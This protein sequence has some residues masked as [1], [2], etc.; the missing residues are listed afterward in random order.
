MHLK[1]KVHRWGNLSKNRKT[2][3]YSESEATLIS[4]STFRLFI[5]RKLIFVGNV[6]L[7]RAVFLNYHLLQKIQRLK[8][9]ENFWTQRWS[10]VDKRPPAP[11]TWTSRKD[12]LRLACQHHLSL[13]KRWK[14]A[15]FNAFLLIR[16]SLI[17]LNNMNLGKLLLA[18]VWDL[19]TA[20]SNLGKSRFIA[21]IFIHTHN[22]AAIRLLTELNLWHNHGLQLK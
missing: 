4:E 8:N 11:L 14:K 19:I 16:L 18:Q 15:G 3:K 10:K 22:T 9:K 21:S 6:Q 13:V 20:Q 2:T 1:D 12:G 7:S 17:T 5:V